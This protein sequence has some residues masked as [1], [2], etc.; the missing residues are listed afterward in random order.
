MLEL[1]E[2]TSLVKIK[3]NQQQ[4]SKREQHR[5]QEWVYAKIRPRQFMINL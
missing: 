5:F 2:Q 1:E 4:S 3:I